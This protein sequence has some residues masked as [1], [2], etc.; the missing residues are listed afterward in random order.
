[1]PFP[2]TKKPHHLCPTTV[3]T[4]NS[5]IHP[6]YTYDISTNVC[7]A[8]YGKSDQSRIQGKNPKTTRVKIKSISLSH[9]RWTNTQRRKSVKLRWR[10][11]RSS[12]ISTFCD[13]TDRPNKNLLYK[14]LKRQ[15]TESSNSYFY[16]LTIISTRSARRGTFL[17]KDGKNFTSKPA[18]S[19]NPERYASS[20]PSFRPR[21]LF[22]S[23][24][25]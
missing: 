16:F 15:R 7:S 21:I 11:I 20:C 14:R 4:V 19:G 6:H 5:Y 13:H 24:I 9:K 18:I 23:T 2:I 17:M 3:M 22:F 1:M 8:S 12:G 25:S 10:Y